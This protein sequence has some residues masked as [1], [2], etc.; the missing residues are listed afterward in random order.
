MENR[1]RSKIKRKR[2]SGF[3]A[4]MR[5]KDGRKILAKRRKGLY[6]GSHK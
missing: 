3:R 2:L 4:R 1:R 6:R 5:T